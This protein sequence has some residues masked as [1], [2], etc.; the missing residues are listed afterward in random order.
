MAHARR[1]FDKALNYDKDMA[2]YMLKK[3]QM[4]ILEHADPLS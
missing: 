4:D 3:M 1:Y 2:E